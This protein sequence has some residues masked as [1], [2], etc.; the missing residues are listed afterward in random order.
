[1]PLLA[2]CLCFLSAADSLSGYMAK[3]P[4]PEVYVLQK[5]R[6]HRVVFLGEDHAVKQNLD[7]AARLI[8][9]LAKAGVRNFGMEFGAEED[10]RAL[11]ALVTAPQYDERLARRLMFHYNVGWPYEEYRGIYRAAWEVNHDRK[12][13][14][15]PFRVLNLSYVY[16]YTKFTGRYPASMQRLFPRGPIEEFRRNVV[17]KEVLE[18]G[19]RIVVL[20]GTSHAFTKYQA[21]SFDYNGPEYVRF[22]GRDFGNLVYRLAPKECFTILLQQPTWSSDPPGKMIYPAGGALDRAFAKP[23][24]FDLKD[25]PPGMLRDDSWFSLGRKDFRLRDLSDGY[26]MLARLKDLRGCTVDKGFVTEANFA[27][28]QRNWPDS[29]WHAAPKTIEEYYDGVSR[30]VNMKDRY[31]VLPDRP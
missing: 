2:A 12:R 24:G 6:S 31:G 14:T 21:A 28:V 8:P 27:E 10:Q 4:A 29:D 25:N 20:T 5:V 13:G 3:Q 18:K 9:L 26:I 11:D 7:F 1:M 19:G 30:Y 23:V 17:R 15:P 16:D 22:D